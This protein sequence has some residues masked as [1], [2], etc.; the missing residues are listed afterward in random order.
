LWASD[1]VGHDAAPISRGVSAEGEYGI[2]ILRDGH[3][4]FTR[5]GALWICDANGDRQ[6]QLT[7]P[8]A[9]QQH[10]DPAVSPD[11]T[12]LVFGEITRGRQG[13]RLMSL[14]LNK[15]NSSSIEL[16][17]HA[18]GPLFTPDG[19][20]IIYST[21]HTQPLR[22]MKIAVAGGAAVPLREGCV[23][24]DLDPSGRLL[25]C[26]DRQS[27]ETV[28]DVKD[29]REVWRG[30][31]AATYPVR[32]LDGKHLAFTNNQHEVGNIWLQTLDSAPP[33]QMTP[34]T[35]A[36]ILRFAFS[37]D[38]KRI[39]FARQEISRNAVLMK[40]LPIPEDSSWT[41]TLFRKVRP[42]A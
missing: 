30:N 38:K 12:T 5:S 7:F 33:Q 23:A 15:E 24:N 35:S 22:A 16:A 10:L 8:T 42:G 28:I 11:E 40:N 37:P 14:R 41:S 4:I 19:S 29:G 26:C 32:W 25:L 34:F 3:V 18:M 2:V 36:Q 21:D 39:V 1:T 6:K 9:D 20:S 27:V 31:I 17:D 13:F